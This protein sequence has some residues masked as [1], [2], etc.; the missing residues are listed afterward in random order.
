MA[1]RMARSVTA[2][3]VLLSVACSV[4]VL[5]AAAGAAACSLDPPKV[6]PDPREVAKTADLVAIVRIDGVEPLTAA[7]DA[8]LQ[9]LL[10]DP[11]LNTPFRYPAPGLRFST[12]RVLKG[13]M[14]NGVLIQNG[15]TNCEVLLMPGQDYVLFAGQP[16]R[17]GD[18]IAPLDGTFYLGKTERDRANLADVELSLTSSNPTPP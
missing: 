7:E 4:S 16:A 6:T 2:K 17:D 8:E 3:R 1:G 13:Q 15:A 12:L 14:P 18:R 10:R 5:V 9:R 11:P